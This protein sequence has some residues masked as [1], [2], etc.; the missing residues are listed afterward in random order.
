MIYTLAVSKHSY[1]LQKNGW[2][3]GPLGPWARG[4]IAG[5]L[6]L[7]PYSLYLFTLKWIGGF[8]DEIKSNFL[9]FKCQ[10]QGMCS[11]SFVWKPRTQD[12][13]YCESCFVHTLY[14]KNL[15]LKMVVWQL[16]VLSCFKLKL[17]AKGDIIF[18][19]KGNTNLRGEFRMNKHKL[20]LSLW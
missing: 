12:H 6:Y 9:S 18:S 8:S 3:Y 17:V 15:K 16:D 11:W 10:K 4:P 13:P 1:S 19:V 14:D 5:T 7:M 2:A 20:K